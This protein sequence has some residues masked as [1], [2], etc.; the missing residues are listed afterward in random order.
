MDRVLQVIGGM[1]RAGAETMIMNTYRAID[2]KK[3]QFDFLVYSDKKQDYEDEI[4]SLGGRVIRVSVKNPLEYISKI[5]DVINK[6]GPYIAIHAHTLHNNAF[7]MLAAKKHKGVVRISH[8]HNTQ[9]QVNVS[10]AKKVYESLTK[11]IIQKESQ[12]WL[13]CG[14]EAGLYLF[15]ERFREHGH[16]V[17]N[18]INLSLYDHR[19]PECENVRKEFKLDADIIIGNI[20]RLT[21]VKNHSFMLKIAEKLKER[22]LN[23]K[24]VFIGQGELKDQ[25]KEEIRKMDLEDVVIMTGVRS[26]IADFLQIFDVFLMPSIFEGNPVTLI[27]AQAS[28]VSCVVSES[29][30]DKIDLG[31]GLINKASLSQ[32]IDFWCDLIVQAASHRVD[33]YGKIKKIFQSKKYDSLSIA[34]QLTNI[35]KRNQN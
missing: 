3:I 34:N 7:A 28:G 14:E 17:N 4:L 30:T 23:F 25:I 12:V 6:Y 18:G 26:D 32:S 15:G 22:N 35:Y 13:A 24:M 1:N 29:I 33:D 27:E 19:N 2:R 11:K 10:F 16:V 5:D 8:S 20:G 21:E 31:L 9:N